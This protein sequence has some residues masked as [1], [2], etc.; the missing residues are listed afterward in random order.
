MVRWTSNNDGVG[1]VETII[2][3]APV[4]YVEK[5]VLEALYRL[6]EDC[7]ESPTIS[8]LAARTGLHRNT[9][10]R[11]LNKLEARGCIDRQERDRAINESRANQ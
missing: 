6:R 3:E 9:V 1:D 5:R 11:A 8:Q 2:A 7:I 4:R 10:A